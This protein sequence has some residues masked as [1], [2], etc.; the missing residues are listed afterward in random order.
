MNNAFIRSQAVFGEEG[1]LKLNNSHV[2]VFGL[3]GVGSY[4]VEALVRAGV[5]EFTL[6]DNDVYSTSNLN[7]QLYAT[8]NTVGK[9]K[10]EVAKARILEINP[11]AKV[12]V[13]NKFVLDGN[14]DGIDFSVFTYVVDAIDT[15]SGKLS[16]V[17][18]AKKAGVNV[19]S[20]MSAGNKLDATKFMVAD[21]YK[22][23]VCPLCKVMRKLCKEAGITELKVVYSEEE[24]I[25]TTSQ[26][27][28]TELKGSRPAPSSVS[29]VP[30]VMG[31]IA[32]GEVIKDVVGI[33]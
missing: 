30:S 4:A 7:R 26:N 28:V 2:A 31:L 19:I 22:T 29:F 13:I 21:L 24:P 12:N 6:V 17:K 32:G 15:I 9:L 25:I 8:I 23:K 27:D 20:C 16:I 10:T 1:Q 11:L 5:G 3:G 18:R 14:D 33:I